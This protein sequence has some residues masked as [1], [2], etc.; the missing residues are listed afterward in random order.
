MTSAI[1]ATSETSKAV[2]RELSCRRCG[3]LVPVDDGTNA[4]AIVW[5]SWECA[6]R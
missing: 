6:L 2:V 4:D 3:Q 1:D 5:C